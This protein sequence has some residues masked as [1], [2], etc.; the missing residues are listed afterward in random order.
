MMGTPPTR[1]IEHL[2]ITVPDHD[3]AL[4]FFTAAFGAIRLYSLVNEQTGP[5]SAQ[6][7]GARNGLRFGTS[8]RAV[9]MLR[10]ANG[11][12][13]EIF[14]IDR[15]SGQPES[16]ISDLG[17]SHFSLTVEDIDLTCA[18]FEEAGG[19]L[20]AGPY[21]LSDQE[22]GRGNRGR[23]GRAPWGLL[24]EMEQLPAAMDYDTEEGATAQRWL[25]DAS[26]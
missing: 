22:A 18:R 14:E 2:G 20:L 11:P 7:V 17:I 15:P 21:D 6:T 10:L 4:A 9:S 23:F 12:N 26:K 16:S 13:L 1:G 25:P 19:V 24:I 5:L 3:A 8:I